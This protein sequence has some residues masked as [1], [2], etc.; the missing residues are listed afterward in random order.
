M[1]KCNSRLTAQTGK[2][3]VYARNPV[4][5]I[6]SWYKQANCQRA[7]A[8]DQQGWDTTRRWSGAL[9]ETSNDGNRQAQKLQV[10]RSL[11]LKI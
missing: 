4:L 2:S 5:E 11:T 9:L 6:V 1:K 8:L 10:A 7:P 3:F